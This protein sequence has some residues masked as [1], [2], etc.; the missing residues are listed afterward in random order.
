MS[1]QRCRQGV[2][3]SFGWAAALLLAANTTWAAAAKPKA[4]AKPDKDGWITLF[5]GKTLEGWHRNPQKIGHGTGGH[6]TVEEGGVLAGEQDPPGSGNGGILLTDQKFGDFELELE[7]KPAWGMDSGLFLR[8]TDEGQCFQMMVD[9]YEGGNVGQFYGEATGG[10]S[11]RTFSF[12]GDVQSG[13]LVGLSTVDHHAPKEVGL[14]SGCSGDEWRK[15]WKRDDWNKVHVRVEGGKYPKITTNINGLEVGVL[16]TNTFSGENYN[17]EEVA[18]TLDEKGHIA[19][20]VH[21]GMGR[22]PVGGRCR[23]R[24]IR[25]REL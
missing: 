22:A 13:K 11:A 6:W 2:C 8:S 14:V 4:A 7:M 15:V 1:L 25:V 10:W 9:Y 23:W 3:K 5:D 12:K 17:K 20:Q 21:G 18:K 19:V 16:D 24:N